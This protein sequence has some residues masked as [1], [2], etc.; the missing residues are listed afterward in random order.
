MSSIFDIVCLADIR[1]LEP[2]EPKFLLISLYFQRYEYDVTCENHHFDLG[3]GKKT[4][5]KD[6]KRLVIFFLNQP[7]V[8]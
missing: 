4:E 7:L 2:R 8:V 3:I 5:N 1:G 6:R